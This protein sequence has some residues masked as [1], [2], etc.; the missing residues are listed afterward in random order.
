[1]TFGGL[2]DPAQAQPIHRLSPLPS[3]SF[4]S[5]RGALCIAIRFA[6]SYPPEDQKS[7]A[8]PV[9]AIIAGRSN[10]LPAHDRKHRCSPSRSIPAPS[11]LRLVAI[12]A[13]TNRIPNSPV[14]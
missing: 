7:L 6:S 10:R 9:A 5:C 11:F 1:V 3:L 12:P 13:H 4:A 14:V 2:V 8:R